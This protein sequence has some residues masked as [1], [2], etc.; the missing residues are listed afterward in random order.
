MNIT[1]Q[2]VSVV[3]IGCAGHALTNPSGKYITL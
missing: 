2:P 1:M 3:R